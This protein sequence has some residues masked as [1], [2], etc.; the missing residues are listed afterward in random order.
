[1]R[2][3]VVN[4]SF[5]AR[6]GGAEGCAA[7]LAGALE[8]RGY[9]VR[10]IARDLARGRISG[11]L[12]LAGEARRARRAGDLVVS[13]C[14][15]P[16]DVV[17]PQEGVH[18]A[19]VAGALA[20]HG[21]VTRTLLASS[22]LLSPKEWAFLAA[23]AKGGA[24][25]ARSKEPP[26]RRY[27]ALSRRIRD[28]MI[29]LWGAPPGAIEVC[30]NG[31][32]GRRFRPPAP[33]ERAEAR[34]A[35]GI[36]REDEVAVLFVSHHFELRGLEQL[37]RALAIARGRFRLLVAGRGRPGR[38]ARLARSLGIDARFLGPVD[39]VRPLHRAADVFALPT[40]YDA[41]SLSTLEALGSGL[42]VVT[43][44]ANG[45]AELLSGREGAVVADARDL[46]ALAA[47]MARLRDPARR[48]VCG[49][50]ARETALAH[51]L[52][53]AIERVAAAVADVIGRPA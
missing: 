45:A 1:M 5:D 27:L 46:G 39:D 40:Y 2:L 22:T 29:R 24:G 18:L 37:V 49:A 41:C 17:Y 47:A 10:R 43:T 13:L 32:D 26:P 48:R 52:E 9:E 20:R 53:A 8:G 16:G 50:A 14:K 25:G 3:A 38:A 33:E 28:D 19:R 4:E 44:R 7:N 36:E 51:P 12:G 31:V 34:A 23:E 35:A 11:A 30:P 6:R 21:R 42:P 15:A